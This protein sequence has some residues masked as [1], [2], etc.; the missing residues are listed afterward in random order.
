[1]AVSC[2][3]RPNASGQYRN[4]SFIVDFAIRQI[5]RSTELFLVLYKFL[6]RH[7]VLGFRAIN[8]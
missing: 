6:G 1:M 8:P 5:P 3:R 4:S 2:M 7:F